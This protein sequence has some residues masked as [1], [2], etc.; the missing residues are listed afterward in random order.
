[1]ATCLNMMSTQQ[2]PE[3]I[4]AGILLM[5]HHSVH[6][7]KIALCVGQGQLKPTA[8][9]D[10]PNNDLRTVVRVAVPRLHLVQ[11]PV[12]RG[13][14]GEI[15]EK[16]TNV[17]QKSTS[18]STSWISILFGMVFGRMALICFLGARIDRL[19]ASN[20]KTYNK[21]QMNQT[22]KQQTV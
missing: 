22:S 2:L 20:G 9:N 16:S 12:K 14:C 1:M 5:L 21:A 17:Q 4:K 10:L 3:G 15:S 13:P 19:S 7:L 18:C 11:R 6:R 8:L